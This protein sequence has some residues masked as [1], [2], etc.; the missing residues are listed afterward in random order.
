MKHKAPNDHLSS[1]MTDL[2]TSLMVI[3]V[4]LLVTKL[5]NQASSVDRAVEYV[6]K[7]I[8]AKPQL[9]KKGETIKKEADVIVLI[10]PNEL[11]SFVRAYKE[12]GGAELSDEGRA[13]LD[14]RI[15]ILSSVI[16]SSR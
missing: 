14:E 13:Y 11:M 1:S 12:Q 2:M 8:E 7:A 16:C 10:V 4:L 6:V 15:P 3:F 5:N 9:F